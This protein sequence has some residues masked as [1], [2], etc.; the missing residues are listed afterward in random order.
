MT[1]IELTVT[2]AEITATTDG[3]L[4]A[5]M[6]GV[7]AVFS[8]DE[9]WDGLEKIAIF[10]AGGK[11]CC[12]R[13]LEEVVTVP[14]EILR[15]AGCTLYVGVYGL[16]PE[17]DLGIPTHWCSAGLVLPGADPEATEG[18]EPT[19]PVWKEAMDK[20]DAVYAAY[21]RGEFTPVCGI[22]YWTEADKNEIRAYV[23][24]AILGGAW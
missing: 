20:A 13:D 7:P 2:G 8:F 24:E 9:H 23:D 6:V 21:Q 17:G 10:R 18:C 22:D 12:V 15:K 4:T 11:S 3:I 16:D 1:T 14:W 19:L 5:G